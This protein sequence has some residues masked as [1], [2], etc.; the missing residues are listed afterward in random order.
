M[1]VFA[2]LDFR[3]EVSSIPNR[4]RKHSIGAYMYKVAG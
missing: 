2:I 4:H 3:M 1:S